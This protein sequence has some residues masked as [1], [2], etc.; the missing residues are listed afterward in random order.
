MTRKTYETVFLACLIS[1]ICALALYRYN[2]RTSGFSEYLSIPM[3]GNVNCVELN[4]PPDSLLNI[5]SASFAELDSLP[6]ISSNIAASIIIY[7]KKHRFKN[8]AELAFINGIGEK[9]LATLLDY[10]KCK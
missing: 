4:A 9:K 5:N 8:T 1:I 6:G 10:I 2:N 3:T 7:R